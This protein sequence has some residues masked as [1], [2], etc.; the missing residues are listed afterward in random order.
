MLFWRIK[1][2]FRAPVTGVYMVFKGK[3]I[4]GSQKLIY[5]RLYLILYF[6]DAV[7]C[8]GTTAAVGYMSNWAPTATPAAS[9]QPPVLRRYKP[10]V[11]LVRFGKPNAYLAAS[12]H[13]QTIYQ[14]NFKLLHP[15]DGGSVFLNMEQVVS[16]SAAQEENT[17]SNE[18]YFVVQIRTSNPKS[19]CQIKH[20]TLESALAQVKELIGVGQN[21]EEAGTTKRVAVRK[22]K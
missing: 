16:I 4:H 19:D 7:D 17:G 5:T 13:T 2:I 6:V 10:A 8:K 18:K 1:G 14:M 20:D 15:I 21:V 22:S 3:L 9:V 11:E 12:L